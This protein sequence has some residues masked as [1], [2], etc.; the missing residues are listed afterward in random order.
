[1]LKGMTV[2]ELRELNL[3]VHDIQIHQQRITEGVKNR[4]DL[5]I[6]IEDTCRLENGGILP[7]RY[8][9]QVH[10][11]KAHGFVAFVP[12]A[13]AASRYFKPLTDLHAALEKQDFPRIAQEHQKLRQ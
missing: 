12:A 13:G 6:P 1:M 9:H 11:E 7:P 3:D 5:F 10:R 4:D 2:P 8:L